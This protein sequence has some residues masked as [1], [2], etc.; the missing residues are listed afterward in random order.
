MNNVGVNER[1]RDGRDRKIRDKIH[2]EIESHI[3]AIRSQ[4]VTLEYLSRARNIL[5]LNQISALIDSV[6]RFC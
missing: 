3:P 5:S 6:F 2:S 1:L 4:I